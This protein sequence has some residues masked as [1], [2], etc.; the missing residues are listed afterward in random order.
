MKLSNSLKDYTDTE[1]N[2]MGK[3]ISV[4][5]DNVHAVDAILETEILEPTKVEN[6][7]YLDRRPIV[8]FAKL[9]SEPMPFHEIVNTYERWCDILTETVKKNIGQYHNPKVV[10]HVMLL[11][12]MV[13]TF[14][15]FFEKKKD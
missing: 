2:A 11:R 14:Q 12:Y 9:E 13:C 3:R 4:Y 7:V 8:E 15:N 5:L 10:E 6:L 1:I